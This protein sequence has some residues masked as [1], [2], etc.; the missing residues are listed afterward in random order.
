[1]PLL[2]RWLPSCTYSTRWRR[3]AIISQRQANQTRMVTGK[4]NM[5][6][7][8]VLPIESS[9]Y[10]LP[11]VTKAC[12]TARRKVLQLQCD[13][14]KRRL[15][16]NITNLKPFNHCIQELLMIRKLS[17]HVFRNGADKTYNTRHWSLTTLVLWLGFDP[18]THF[19]AFM[20][21]TQIRWLTSTGTVWWG[22]DWNILN[23]R[24]GGRS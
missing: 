17:R 24:R 14:K 2:R 9:T 15:Q 12:H 5:S 13:P 10:P 22:L 18:H 6:W 11:C 19:Q 8:T 3:H 4:A 23:G 7:V 16:G 21:I 1:M 20:P